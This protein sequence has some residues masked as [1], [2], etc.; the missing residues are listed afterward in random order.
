M[1]TKLRSLGEPRLGI[2]LIWLVPT[3]IDGR[4]N[5]MAPVTEEELEHF[6]QVTGVDAEELMSRLQRIGAEYQRNPEA[7]RAEILRITGGDERRADFLV[8]LMQAA[9]PDG[10]GDGSGGESE[11]SGGQVIEFRRSETPDEDEPR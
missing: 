11:G 6:R 4:P 10:G 3:K 7:L 5:V 1:T 9:Q 2:A 8:E